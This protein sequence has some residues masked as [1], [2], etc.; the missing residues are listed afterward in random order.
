[1]HIHLYV[2]AFF[3]NKKKTKI[4]FFLEW[5]EILYYP[6][7]KNCQKVASSLHV[8]CGQNVAESYYAVLQIRY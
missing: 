7:I 3:T 2:Y 4:L 8:T 1:M 5:H 6:W